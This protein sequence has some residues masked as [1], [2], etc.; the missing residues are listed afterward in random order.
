MSAVQTAS[1]VPPRRTLAERYPALRRFMRHRVA[2]L[3]VGVVLFMTLFSF[4]GPWLIPFND[5]DQMVRP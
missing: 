5:T 2:L 4:V 1:L 3:G